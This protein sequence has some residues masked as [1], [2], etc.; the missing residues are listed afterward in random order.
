MGHSEAIWTSFIR[1]PAPA[2]MD[3]AA[4]LHP[5]CSATSAISSAFAF[6]ST[7]GDFSF[8]THVPSPNCFSDDSLARAVTLTWMIRVAMDDDH[9]TL[10][11]NVRKRFPVAANTALATAGAASGTPASPSPPGASFDSMNSMSICGVSLLR[12]I[13]KS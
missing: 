1:P 11:G 8:A 13:A 9:A 12:R 3:T 5:N 6:P 2:L 10:S 7:G 4:F